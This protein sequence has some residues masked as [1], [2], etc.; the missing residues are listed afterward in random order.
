ML[1]NPQRE[2][3][4][5]AARTMQI[6][7]AALAAG[8][9]TFFAIVLISSP[10]GQPAAGAPV[11][12]LIAYLAAAFALAAIIVWAVMPRVIAGRIRQAIVDGKPVPAAGLSG[13]L[14][15]TDE[16]LQISPL[17]TM[18]QTPL[19]IGSAILE[20]AAL[21]NLIAYM[22]E[23][24]QMS[25]IVAGALLL[26]MLSQIPTVSRLEAWVEGELATIDQLRLLRRT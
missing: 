16:R 17:V 18:Y 13:N 25:L 22:I 2:Y 1:T 20:G 14:P 26:L 15:M 21:F 23:R 10:K 5:L 4:K 7:V 8:V 6:I 24:Q 3:L 12:P 11:E 19:I 9:G